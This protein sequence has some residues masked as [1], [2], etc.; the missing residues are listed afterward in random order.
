VELNNRN[1]V[2]GRTGQ[3]FIENHFIDE[4]AYLFHSDTGCYDVRERII[5]MNSLKYM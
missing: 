4:V 1:V 3:S 2:F 5:K